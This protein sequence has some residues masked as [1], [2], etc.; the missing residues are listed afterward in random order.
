MP[1]IL[2]RSSD[3]T[4]AGVS[5]RDAFFNHID[6]LLERGY[7]PGVGVLM[8]RLYNMSNYSLREGIQAGDEMVS[9]F[10]KTLVEGVARGNMVAR[11]SGV[12]FVV[13]IDRDDIEAL[14]VKLRSTLR[15]ADATASLSV[16]AGF[17]S[18]RDG[19]DARGLV[20]RARY[21]L[22]REDAGTEAAVCYFDE[23]MCLAFDKRRYVIDNLDDAIR[24]GEIEAYAQP[25]VR[26]ITG[27]IC[28]VEV[29]A[30]WRS[31]R[32]GMI[33]PSEF[34]PQLEQ[35]RQVHKLDSTVFGLACKQW[36]EA[37]DMGVEVPFGINLSRLDF[38]L[39]DIYQVICDAMAVYGVPVE[40]VHIEVTE[41]ALIGSE[42]YLRNGIKRF[43]DAGFTVYMDDFGTGYSSLEGLRDSNYD[44]VKLD[45]SLID[46]VETNERSRVITAD[47]VS[48]VKRLG[49][50]TLCEGVETL[51][52]LRFLR[53]VGCEKAQGYLT[54]KPM[55]HDG[56]MEWLAQEAERYTESGLNRYLNKVGQVNL[57]DGTRA[58]V[59]G[60]EAAVFLGS[61][62]VAIAEIMDDHI[63]CLAANAA[64]DDL[65]HR[66]G[67]N[68]FEE[69]VGKISAERGEMRKRFVL[70]AELSKKTK[71]K[72]GV[73]FISG[74]IFGTVEI[75][76][77]A[78]TVERSAF[79]IRATAI[80]SCEAI[81]RE[82]SLEL[83]SP[84]L[85]SL[86]KRI[87]LFD[88]A[89]GTSQNLYL[90]TPLLR[91]HRMAGITLAEVREFCDRNLHP[92]D[93]S[94]FLSFYDLSTLD[95]R[96]KERGTNYDVIKLRVRVSHDTYADHVF[97][98][99][100]MMVQGRGQVL[101]TLRVAEA[102]TEN[103]HQIS[104]DARIS[105]AVLLKAVLE[106]TDRYVFW[107]DDKRRFLGANQAFL[108]YYGFKS[109]SEILGKTDEEVGWHVDSLPFREDEL[110]VLNGDVVLRS[111]GTCY[112]RNEL[113]KIEANKRPIE[114]A[115]EIVGLL[116]YF[117][118]MGPAEDE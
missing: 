26:V 92:A 104:G 87:D 83:A 34:V 38:E 58:D 41:S 68:S 91:S 42:D 93:R 14:M 94:R 4:P 109:L 51:E 82:R 24:R 7:V 19:V 39:C 31:E 40:D 16:H 105:D 90:S 107:K 101:S 77:I 54:G 111:R 28:E 15:K 25:I 117:R 100:P 88:L 6:K 33:M 37:K 43:R 55:D 110:R 114:V 63:F 45:K 108:D 85:Y 67:Y 50:Q 79:L 48:M 52:Q 53:M 47:A 61:T 44:V 102:D 62:P 21:A 59:Q 32:F 99:I 89:Q 13:L 2:R 22:E 69:V 103:S 71:S 66:I 20:D 18:L 49:M 75:E 96:V 29:L 11:E 12:A 84:F 95:A 23:N 36:R 64:F 74:G 118:D 17:C 115:G 56:V 97:T 65:L 116:G 5:S 112:D 1:A 73:D 113:R 106:G 86:Y 27:R 60:V 57:I 72:R 35:S 98:L 8:V 76:H 3:F 9:L 10:I 70:A 81:E 46:Q 80:S 78:S 30:R